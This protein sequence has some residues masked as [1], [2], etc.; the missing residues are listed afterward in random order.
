MGLLNN[1]SVI[2][3]F[4]SNDTSLYTREANYLVNNKNGLSILKVRWYSFMPFRD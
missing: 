1:P 3:E 4:F 2:L